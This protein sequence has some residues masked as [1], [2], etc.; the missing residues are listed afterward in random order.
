MSALRELEQSRAD[1]TVKHHARSATSRGVK[2]AKRYKS[3][4]KP[5]HAAFAA[6]HKR[7]NRYAVLLLHRRAGKTMWAVNELIHK[8]LTT[9]PANPLHPCQFAYICPERAQAKKNAWSYLKQYSLFAAAMSGRKPKFHESELWVELVNGA[10]IFVLGA[11]NPESIRG[12]Y[13][14]GVILDESQGMNEHFFNTILSPTLFDR[15]GWVV[16]AGTPNGPGSL[17]HQRYLE[18]LARPDEIDLLVL[19][20][21]ESGIYPK[22]RLEKERQT[23]G[24]DAF[25]QEWELSWDAPARGSYYAEMLSRAEKE[26]RVCDVVVNPEFPIESAWDLGYADGSAVVF[27][28]R[29]ENKT[30]YVG[31]FFTIE[32]TFEPLLDKY[33]LYMRNLGGTK[34]TLWM[35]HDAKHRNIDTGGSPSSILD[36]LKYDYAIIPKTSDVEKDIRLVKEAFERVVIDKRLEEFLN[37]VKNYHRQWSDSAKVFLKKADHDQWSHGA[38]AFRYS[39]MGWDLTRMYK[40]KRRNPKDIGDYNRERAERLTFDQLFAMADR[41]QRRNRKYF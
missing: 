14:D 21:S 39:I 8:A 37:T 29:I 36:R 19:K 40:P 26:G 1:D 34:G 35:P 27:F 28:Q 13:Y 32:E 7:K 18:A 31:Y 4:Y 10:K 38:D 23:I 9:K 3:P 17:L 22:E 20:A 5:R 12:Q 16:F 6:F 33:E 24:E 41:K 25:N 2:Q 15:Q 11:S 30:Y